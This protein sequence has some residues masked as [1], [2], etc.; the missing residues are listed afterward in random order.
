MS[1]DGILQVLRKNVENA[2]PEEIK[3]FAKELR[4]RTDPGTAIYIVTRIENTLK[5]I[6]EYYM[7]TAN[8]EKKYNGDKLINRLFRYP[9]PLS[10]FSAKID[11][12]FSMGWIDE[13][14]WKHLH[15]I[16]EIR[17]TF[18]HSDVEINFENEEIKNLVKR[19]PKQEFFST[20][21]TVERFVGAVWVFVRSRLFVSE[22]KLHKHRRDRQR[23]EKAQEAREVLARNA[24]AGGTSSASAAVA[25]RKPAPGG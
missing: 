4:R 13:E 18:A 6:I 3:A 20:P 25:P 5:E 15:T 10:S 19:L 8:L 11:Y 16:R 21:D 2:S 12:V 22:A 24:A 1:I 7:E 9:G 14:T 17:N 23:E